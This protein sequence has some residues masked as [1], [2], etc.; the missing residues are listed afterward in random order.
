MKDQQKSNE[1]KPEVQLR[2]LSPVIVLSS[3]KVENTKNE[4]KTA[5]YKK[6]QALRRER[7]AGKTQME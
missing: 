5:F 4:A 7:R 2:E 3:A 6:V 1:E